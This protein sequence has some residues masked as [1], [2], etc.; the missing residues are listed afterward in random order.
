MMKSHTRQS[1]WLN[2]PPSDDV[3]VKEGI[4]DAPER[5]AADAGLARF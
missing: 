2:H 5:E 3:V 4:E 1:K